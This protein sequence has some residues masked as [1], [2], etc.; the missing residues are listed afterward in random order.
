MLEASIERKGREHGWRK[1]NEHTLRKTQSKIIKMLCEDA[2]R[3]T[4]K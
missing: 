4:M 2:M 3:K 1:E